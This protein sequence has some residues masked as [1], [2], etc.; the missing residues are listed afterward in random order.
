M[1]TYNLITYK[2]LKFL[3]DAANPG[4]PAVNLDGS[5]GDLIQDNFKYI[6]DNIV[7]SG[8]GQFN[9]YIGLGSGS[10]NLP[11]RLTFLASTIPSG[12]IN[13]GGDTNLYRSFAGVLR[14]DNSF[15][16]Q[17]LFSNN[18]AVEVQSNRNQPS[19]YPS[20][21]AN[22]DLIARILVKY[23][24]TANIASQ[25]LAGGE[26]AIANDTGIL[27][28]GDG[29][30][31]GGIAVNSDNISTY[32]ISSFTSGTSIT[33]DPTNADV[34]VLKCY[35]TDTVKSFNVNGTIS[36]P[37][38]GSWGIKKGTRTG[39]KLTIIFDL[40]ATTSDGFTSAA[41]LVTVN[42]TRFGWTSDY[43]AY[44]SGAKRI[45]A[46]EPQVTSDP[47]TLR[48][49]QA[50]N[51]VWDG[52]YW[53]E[54]TQYRTIGNT[55][56]TFG[57]AAGAWAKSG[58]YSIAV[59]RELNQS[60]TPNYSAVFGWKNKSTADYTLIGG[61]SNTIT[62]SA[63]SIFWGRNLT[64]P[65]TTGGDGYQL[66]MG[67]GARPRAPLSR[68]WGHA[69]GTTDWGCAQG[70]DYLYTKITTDASSGV[71]DIRPAGAGGHLIVPPKTVINCL[72]QLVGYNTTTPGAAT[73]TGRFTIWRDDLN[74]TSLLES[75]ELSRAN[76][77]SMSGYNF[78]ISADDTNERPTFTVVGLASNT[79]RWTLRLTA[80]EAAGAAGL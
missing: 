56:D 3:E 42:G 7:P 67:E 38:I 44:H 63:H 30:T 68:T 64:N 70:A 29:V 78:I 73:V 33:L 39:Q 74:N 59:G 22:G 62:T 11:A 10:A 80:S 72:Y 17:S 61:D 66:V 32:D 37:T 13:F 28:R 8:G 23:D 75:I 50:I 58:N 1:S 21:D 20:L 54:Q 48:C 52:K 16:A 47:V 41:V 55:F 25:V 65:N 77:A 36:D 9:G 18:N 49:G 26:L 45:F 60:S 24:T 12:G 76:S 6:A 40:Q 34:L 57:F 43:Y 69:M 79:I 2:N 14:T 31:S 51:L 19:G 46:T 15:Y 71:M 53:Q 5:G 27:Y 4:S 35:V